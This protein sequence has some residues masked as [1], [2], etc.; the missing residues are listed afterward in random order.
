MF[1]TEVALPPFPHPASR[2]EGAPTL[3]DSTLTLTRAAD[4][5]ILIAV[6]EFH[7]GS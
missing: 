1:L 7:A 6:D 2:Y 3:I 5:G 4:V